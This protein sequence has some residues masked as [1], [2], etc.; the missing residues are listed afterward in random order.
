MRKKQATAVADALGEDPTLPD[1]S[2]VIGGK[3]RHLCFDVNAI[4][5]VEKE[6]K[7]N[8]LREAFSEPTFT[9][10]RA[11]LFATLLHDDPSLTLDEVGSWL[12]F[13]NLDTAYNA[14]RTTWFAS[15]PESDEQPG[16]APAQA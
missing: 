7:L 3:E 6:T 10:T 2:I 1:V 9:N 5:V 14:I 13:S 8:L 4:V 12:N 15:K 16:E 11:L